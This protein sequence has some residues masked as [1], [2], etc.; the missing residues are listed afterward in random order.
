MNDYSTLVNTVV[1][2][3]GK[4]GKVICVDRSLFWERRDEYDAYVVGNGWAAWIPADALSD[5][6]AGLQQAARANEYRRER[7]VR[8]REAQFAHDMG[9]TGDAYW[10]TA[11]WREL[12]REQNRWVS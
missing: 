10:E 8:A 5:L 1:T 7:W 4:V 6:Y 2:V 11:D 9:W 3:N 12:E